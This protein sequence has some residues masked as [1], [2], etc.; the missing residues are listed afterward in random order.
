MS[1]PNSTTPS[2]DPSQ[3][4]TVIADEDAKML[5]QFI[6]I[7]ATKGALYGEHMV[8]SWCQRLFTYECK[9]V[10]LA[11]VHVILALGALFILM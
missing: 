10:D 6:V 1:A 2:S 11:G 5:E 7:I 4:V 3:Q 9:L 8:Y